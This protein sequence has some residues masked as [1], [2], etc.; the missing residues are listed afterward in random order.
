MNMACRAYKVNALPPNERLIDTLSVNLQPERGMAGCTSVQMTPIPEKTLNTNMT[1]RNNIFIVFLLVALVAGCSG[2]APK[3]TE[4]ERKE[5]AAAA[6]A[7]NTKG[8][9]TSFR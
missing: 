8:I 3:I 5:I 4:G 6:V 1:M 9:Y 2:I 7:Y